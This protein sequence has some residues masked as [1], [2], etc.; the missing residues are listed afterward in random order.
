MTASSKA[1]AAVINHF[2]CFIIHHKAYPAGM[3]FFPFM[4]QIFPR[5]MR[6]HYH[7]LFIKGAFRQVYPVV[8]AFFENCEN[9]V[10]HFIICVLE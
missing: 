8:R 10:F 2:V 4:W 7:N 1:P 3:L 6:N 5:F 9:M